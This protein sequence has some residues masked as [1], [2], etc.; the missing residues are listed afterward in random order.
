MPSKYTPDKIN[1]SHNTQPNSAAEMIRTDESLG[2]LA[3]QNRKR[4]AG[5]YAAM[6]LWAR[7]GFISHGGMDWDIRDGDERKQ[8]DD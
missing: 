1:R 5:D 6:E 2:L 7:E 8:E 4:Y 3:I